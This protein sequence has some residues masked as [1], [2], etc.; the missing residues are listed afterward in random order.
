MDILP[1]LP[2]SGGYDNIITALDVFSLF[3]RI[4]LHIQSQELLHQPI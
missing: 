2:P 4:C 1:N 3:V